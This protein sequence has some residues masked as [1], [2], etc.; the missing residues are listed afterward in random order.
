MLSQYGAAMAAEHEEMCSVA[1]PA[2]VGATLEASIL[3]H[4]SSPPEARLAF[5]SPPSFWMVDSDCKLHR[6]NALA[7]KII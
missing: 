7:C 2:L 5:L 6:A 4:G 3:G 1:V